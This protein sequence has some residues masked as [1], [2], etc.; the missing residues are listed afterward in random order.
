M[1]VWGATEVLFQTMMSK[2]G[3]AKR[4]TGHTLCLPHSFET[5]QALLYFQ[6]HKDHLC[7]LGTL[8]NKASL[9]QVELVVC[10]LLV[11]LTQN[12]RWVGT[13]WVSGHIY[14]YMSQCGVRSWQ[15]SFWKIIS[16]NYSAYL[17]FTPVEFQGNALCGK[18]ASAASCWL[19]KFVFGCVGGWYHLD[20]ITT[21]VI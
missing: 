6:P 12:Y 13:T 17:E 4:Q 9:G 14:T 3:N 16:K 10:S 7:S 19:D 20:D 11:V 8:T 5:Q 18:H 2:G 15:V 21:E 1:C